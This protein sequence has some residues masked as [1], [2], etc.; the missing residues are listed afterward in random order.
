MRALMSDFIPDVPQK[1]ISVLA[2]PCLE[3]PVLVNMLLFNLPS[4]VQY[5]K[6]EKQSIYGWD[7]WRLSMHVVSS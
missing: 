7:I 6:S 5:E 1:Q 3:Q 2:R 4:K